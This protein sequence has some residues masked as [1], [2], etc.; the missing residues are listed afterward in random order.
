MQLQLHQQNTCSKN[1]QSGK[2]TGASEAL[3]SRALNSC[4]DLSFTHQITL[5]F[6]RLVVC[7]EESLFIHNIRDM[8]VRI[9]N[10]SFIYLNN[11]TIQYPLVTLRILF[12]SIGCQVLHT[13]RETPPNKHGLCALSTDSDHC[14][15]AYPGHSTV[16]ELQ[17]FD[18]LHL[19]I[20]F[21]S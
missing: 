9:L 11:N 8:K 16:G 17:I 21:V 20:S 12:Y 7:L 10:I 1:E 6:Q 19:V 3:C 15:L 13:I 2:F 14:Y 5:H 18:A 4:V